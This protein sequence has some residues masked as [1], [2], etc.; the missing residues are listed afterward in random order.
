MP[1][2]GKREFIMKK[3]IKMVTVTV[4]GKSIEM[5]AKKCAT[6][7]AFLALGIPSD[8]ALAAC[9]IAATGTTA[10]LKQYSV[11]WNIART[12]ADG[13]ITSLMVKETSDEI[14]STSAISGQVI[15][16]LN[17]RKAKNRKG[18]K[19]EAVLVG[20]LA[21]TVLSRLNLEDTIKCSIRYIIP[22][23]KVPEAAVPVPAKPKAKAKGKGK[24]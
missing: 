19:V 16:V 5:S 13:L 11:G 9:F 17:D 23:R 20:K 24:A 3:E 6:Y 14:E 7:K 12:I 18:A 1:L 21:A 10:R 22:D 15:H 8:K 2:I 4:D